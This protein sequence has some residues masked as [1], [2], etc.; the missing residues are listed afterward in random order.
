MQLFYQPALN[1]G[2]NH[3]NAAESRHAIKVL[4]LKQG[5]V[6]HLTDGSGVFYQARILDDSFERC[7]FE[8]INS[9][10]EKVYQGFR[11][12]AIATVKNPDRMEF[13]M[14]KAVEIGIDRVSFFYCKNSARKTLKTERLMKKAVSAMKQSIKARLPV[15]DEMVSFTEFLQQVNTT[16][17]YIAC[18]DFDNPVALKN[19]L[20][21]DNVVMIGPE[22]DFTREE[23]QKAQHFG[24]RKVSLGPGR[25][26][27]ET[28]GIVATYILNVFP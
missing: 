1:K 11:H 24:F 23:M 20:K 14:E 16:N 8:L 2:V 17:R 6:I 4:R 18:V 12:I 5:D 3:L 13:F 22:G 25:L 21:T 27:T 7:T 19:E 28:A 26:R 9:E 15:I 10:K